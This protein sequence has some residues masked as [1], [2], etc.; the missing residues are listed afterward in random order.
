[1][2]LTTYTTI[3]ENGMW[4]SYLTTTGYACDMLYYHNRGYVLPVIKDSGRE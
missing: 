4:V 2:L 1:M 3:T